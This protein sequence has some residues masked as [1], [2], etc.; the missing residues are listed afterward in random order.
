MRMHLRID[1]ETKK[2]FLE[3]CDERAVTPSKLIRQWIDK[4][5]EEAEKEKLN[6]E[7]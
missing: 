7:F 4:Y 2:R 6:R 5:I 1:P 3:V